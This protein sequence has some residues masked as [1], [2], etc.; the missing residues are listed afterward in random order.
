MGIVFCLGLRLSSTIFFAITITSFG[1]M[2]RL[3]ALAEII[4][5]LLGHRPPA[6]QPAH[7]VARADEVVVMIAGEA[8]S[9]QIGRPPRHVRHRH[10][11]PP[12]AASIAGTTSSRTMS[13]G[14]GAAG[15]GVRM[16]G[17]RTIARTSR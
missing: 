11:F 6:Q 1:R 5:R 7:R 14:A 2:Q 13:L 15:V 4:S 17:G 9:T 3:Y 10:Q 12:P 16:L 8:I